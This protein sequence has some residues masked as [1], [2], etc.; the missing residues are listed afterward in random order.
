MKK[1]LHNFKFLTL[2][3]GLMLTASIVNA[4]TRTASA[5]GLW[6][7]TAT[8]GGLS[9][10]TS[11]ND[12]IINNGV[13][14]TV[15]AASACKSIVINTG[16]TPAGITVN[17]GQ[18][19]TVASIAAVGGNIDV[20]PGT[21]NTSARTITLTGTA[22][23]VCEALTMADVAPTFS[24]STLAI[25]SGSATVS[26][27]ITFNGAVGA[28]NV[29]TNT[30]GGTL[31]IG[32]T[33]SATNGLLTSTNGFVNYNGAAQTVRSNTYDVLTVSGS[34]VKTLPATLTI[35][36]DFNISGSA[37]VTTANALVVGNDLVLSNTASFTTGA[38]FSVA[39]DVTVPTG[40]SITIGGFDFLVTGGSGVTAI[41]GTITSNST[42]GTKSF[43]DFIVNSGGVFNSTAN[44]NY[45]IAG[46]LA[47]NTGATFT[48]GTGTWSF[49]NGNLSGTANPTITNAAFTT[50]YS[51]SG[52]F[53]FVNMDVTG[54]GNI[55]FT[56]NGTI[57]V[58]TAL[59]G[60]DEFVNG[61]GDVFNF[62]GTSIGVAAFTKTA[63]DNL[64]NYN[65]AAQNLSTGTY[66]FLTLSGSGIKTFSA[67]TSTT[68]NDVLSIQGT[69]TVGGASPV[70]GSAATILEYKGSAAQTTSNIEF[71][72]TSGTNPTNLRIDN[73]A[74]VTLLAAKTINGALTLTNGY[75]TTTT[76]TL[77]SI[78]TGGSATTAN[79][80]FVNGP[81]AKLKNT[82]ALFTF[83]VGNLTGGLRTIG[84]TPSGIGA[85]T[86][87]ASFLS[88]DPRTVPLGNVLAGGITQIS[89]C[90]YWN[91]AKTAGATSARVTVSWPAVGN[92]CGSTNWGAYVGQISSLSVGHHDGAGWKNEGQVSFTGTAV[93]GGTI[94]STNFLTTFSPFVLASTS[95]LNAL[96]VTFDDVKAFEKGTGVQIEWSNLTEKDV[97]N[98]VVERSA[99]GRDF[100]AIS[101]LASRSNLSDKQSYLSFDGSPLSG[102]NYYRI[103]VVEIDGKIIYSKVLKVDIGKNVKGITLYPNPVT[104][105]DISIGFT[106]VKGQYTLR[107]VNNAGQEVYTKQ[108]VHPGGS[109]SQSVTLPS[110]LKTGVYNLM[111][112]GDNYRENKK[113]IMQ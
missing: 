70:Y 20:N 112:S 44:E 79:G 93:T 24:A 10:P 5:T 35:G 12:V 55:D 103:K 19:L 74:G 71:S 18:S 22:T 2:A 4:Q 37:S 92:T 30:S 50:N 60:A 17:T 107:V 78:G 41:G 81:L 69:A 8:W 88:T 6:S 62:G 21:D 108:I 23:L 56:N 38:N 3:L 11:V 106:A 13:I 51:N 86:Y 73:T 57:T 25:G 32:G 53:T 45:S 102:T 31:F 90:E 58:T 111:I 109:I 80:A 85:A 9:V 96:P 54:A 15:G 76:G 65:G 83:P 100:T 84:V 64:V 14:V 89:A 99:N 91:L 46:D 47:V 39:D 98:Y 43:N 26:S 72:G 82:V 66:E 27:S 59:T 16:N 1:Y 63:A 113:F 34:G 52:T 94:T 49:S 40:T 87:Q 110:S 101:Q 77:L 36:D 48:P 67:V 75:L 97:L 95:S 104:G 68:V 42:A 61:A 105:S 28:E 7:N 29:I 33:I